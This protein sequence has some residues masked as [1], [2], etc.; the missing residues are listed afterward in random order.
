MK[1]NFRKNDSLDVK[2]PVSK[3]NIT[4]CKC[5]VKYFRYGWI[6]RW[7]FTSSYICKNSA[8]ICRISIRGC[9]KFVSLLSVIVRYDRSGESVKKLNIT[10]E[11]TRFDF[12]VNFSPNDGFFSPLLF[13]LSLNIRHMSYRDCSQFTR[14]KMFFFHPSKKKRTMDRNNNALFVFGTFFFNIVQ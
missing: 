4:W 9:C 7:I 14:R 8:Q 10:Y 5:V 1:P 13:S 2:V 12:I 6:I 3:P 11:Y